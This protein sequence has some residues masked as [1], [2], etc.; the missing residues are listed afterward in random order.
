[1]T[2]FVPPEDPTPAIAEHLRHMTDGHW[3]DRCR[4]CLRRRAK[5]GT[6]VLPED[7]LPEVTIGDIQSVMIGFTN[8]LDRPLGAPGDG[9]AVER[10]I[11]YE[12]FHALASGDVEVRDGR[13]GCDFHAGLHCDHWTYSAHPCCKCGERNCDPRRT[14]CTEGRWMR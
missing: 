6:G 7:Y 12:Y 8:L 9:E 3:H 13:L 10:T 11:T 14:A 2:G 5:G 1:M 4:F